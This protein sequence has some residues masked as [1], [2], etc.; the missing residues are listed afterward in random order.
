M[1]Q[2]QLARQAVDLVVERL[3]PGG[4]PVGQ[5]VVERMHSCERRVDRP[6]T[7]VMVEETV[8]RAA[9]LGRGME[10]QR[11]SRKESSTALI[12]SCTCAPSSKLPSLFG[13]PLV[14]SVMKDR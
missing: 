6:P 5:L 4:R 13:S 2:R 12:N 1:R 7:I 3:E 11:R 14:I 8:E 10:I 9:H